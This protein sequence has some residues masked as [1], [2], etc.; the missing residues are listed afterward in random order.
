M[1]I[2]DDFLTT[3]NSCIL[4]S[5]TTKTDQLELPVFNVNLLTNYCN[6]LRACPLIY[7]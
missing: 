2:C 4:K 7:T 3:K 6:K 1:Q 5:R